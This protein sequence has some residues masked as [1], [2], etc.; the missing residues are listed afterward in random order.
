MM[1]MSQ[2][3]VNR[4]SFSCVALLYSITYLNKKRTLLN[5]QAIQIKK[6]FK[7]RHLC[8]LSIVFVSCNDTSNN[9]IFNTDSNSFY[10]VK[11]YFI[12]QVNSIDSALDIS[13][14]ITN[15]NGTK[16]SSIIDKRK[17]L[18]LAQLFLFSDI[19]SQ[20]IKKFY[21]ES[22]FQDLTTASNTF[23]YTTQNN[24]LTVRSLDVLLDTS[25]QQ[26]KRVFI[27]RI[28]SKGDTTITEKSGWKT[29]EKFFINKIIQ[30]P[31]NKEYTEQISVVWHYYN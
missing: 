31:D 9:Q 24:E 12:N 23:S 22:I 21:K 11:E 26:V 7:C 30:L 1:N 8:L 28:E 16:D 10:P 5:S 4:L 3:P 27:M 20:S 13:L 25:T 15:K 19:N 29:D 2:K 17:L 6:K 14:I 18:E